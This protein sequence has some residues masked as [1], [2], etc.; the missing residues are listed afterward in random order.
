MNSTARP[1][2]LVILVFLATATCFFAGCAGSKSAPTATG[3]ATLPSVAD[4][5]RQAQL[6]AAATEEALQELPFADHL[7]LPRSFYW[8]SDHADRMDQIGERLVT[9]AIGMY[10]RG[11]YYFVES[12]RSLESC[13]YPRGG[14]FVDQQGIDLGEDFAPISEAGGEVKRAFRAYQFDIQQIRC[15]LGRNL[16]PASA[17]SLLPIMRKAGV[18]SASLQKALLQALQ[19]LEHAKAALPQGAPSAG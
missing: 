16:T 13:A 19:A 9:H 15:V 5:Y 17:R 18:D 3:N 14:R 10:Y 12:P 6:Q 4:D 7:D 8:F 1:A 2:A 11:T